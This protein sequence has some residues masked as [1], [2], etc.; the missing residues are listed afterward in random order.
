MKPGG[1]RYQA[2]TQVKVLSPEIK[3]SPIRPTCSKNMEG[4]ILSSALA[5]RKELGG[6]EVRCMIPQRI[7]RNLGEP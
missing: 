3:L 1:G 6:V 7:D 5:R 4:S 2:S